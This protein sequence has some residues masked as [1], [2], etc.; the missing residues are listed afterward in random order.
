MY[1]GAL[2]LHCYGIC[3]TVYLHY[4]LGELYLHYYLTVE[5]RRLTSASLCIVL[6]WRQDLWN[7]ICFIGHSFIISTRNVTNEWHSHCSNGLKI[8][9]RRGVW[10]WTFLQH[11]ALW[12][13]SQSGAARG[14]PAWKDGTPQ[15]EAEEAFS[16]CCM[17]ERRDGKL[18]HVS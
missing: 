3:I 8:F 1:L 12:I 14:T 17:W 10:N 4:Y 18:K 2:Y 13:I 7:K 5:E 6:F 11:W 9:L 16:P 15:S